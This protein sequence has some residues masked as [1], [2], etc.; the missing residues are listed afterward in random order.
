MNDE[1]G[2]RLKTYESTES[3][4]R[5][6]KLLPALS[7]IDGKTFH[8]FTRN[9]EKP[10]DKRFCDLM[11][12]TT[13]FLV[14]QTNACM[15]Y[16]QSDEMSLA[17]ISTDFNSQIFFDGKIQKM[18]SVLAS[19]TTAFFNENFKNFFQDF[20]KPSLAYFDCRV[21]NVPNQT[22]AS[23]TFLWREFDAVRHSVLNAG[24]A[25]YSHK[26]L[27]NKNIK[28]AQELL[29]QKGINWNDYPSF[30]KRGSYVQRKIIKRKFTT[31]E[32]E[33]LPMQHDARKNSDLEVE[34][35]EY[36]IVD[37]PVFSQV[38]NRNEVV[39]LGEKPKTKI[40]IL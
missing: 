16:T 21:W 36:D 26:Q 14:E 27:F 20:P 28:E 10:Y 3:S 33:K 6:M 13:K 17:W 37:M 2:N 9:M 32:I 23:N 30:Y 38:V 18:T 34:R 5:L 24:Y 12:E 31:E 40:D 7:R 8:N 25:F 35:T 1:L 22:E 19:M 4:R 29:F 15:G 11:I 39:F